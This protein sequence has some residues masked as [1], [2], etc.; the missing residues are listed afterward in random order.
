ML[1]LFLLGALLLGALLLP[2][3]SAATAPAGWAETNGRIE[4]L[5]TGSYGTVQDESGQ[6]I[7]QTCS[8]VVS[9]SADGAAYSID[10]LISIDRT[11]PE[12]GSTVTVAFD[13]ANPADAKV[14]VPSIEGFV[15]S[16]A[17]V[18]AVVVAL[19]LGIFLVR[20]IRR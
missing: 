20:R 6:A 7:V 15:G 5:T 11:C 8:G 16:A 2:L 3:F 9:Y 13:P 19:I 12:V 17:R 4:S 18:L 14:P 10:T 1:G